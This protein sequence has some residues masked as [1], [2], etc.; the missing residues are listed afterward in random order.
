[1]AGSKAAG[2]LVLIQTSLLF[3][4]KYKLVSITTRFKAGFH[5][6]ATIAEKKVQRSYGNHSPAIAATTI[7]EIDFSSISAIIWKPSLQNRRYFFAFFRR[8]RAIASRARSAR[9]ARREGRLFCRLMEP[10][11]SDRSDSNNTRMHCV[12]DSKIPLLEDLSNPK[13]MSSLSFP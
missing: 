3:L 10:L 7:A 1:M 12:P 13:F 9:H 6:I 8:A 11:S 2:D 4:C 5:M